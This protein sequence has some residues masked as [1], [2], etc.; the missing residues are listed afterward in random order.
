M[1]TY[2]LIGCGGFIGTIARYLLSGVPYKYLDTSFP[3]GILLVNFIGALLIG[4]FM[5]FSITRSY[6]SDT[7]RMFVAIGIFG[8]FTTFSTFSY[9]TIA[10][11]RSAQYFYAFLNIFLTNILCLGGTFLGMKLVSL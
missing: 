2:L 11:F 7:A 1:K 10:L 6:I 3:I 9:E 4:Y 8:G 5:E